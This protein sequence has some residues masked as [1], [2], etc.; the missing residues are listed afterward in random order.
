MM[1]EFSYLIC[2]DNFVL[3]VRVADSS[4]VRLLFEHFNNKI[5]S[6]EP[7]ARSL[8]ETEIPSNPKQL[9]KNKVA[10]IFFS[11]MKKFDGYSVIIDSFPAGIDELGKSLL[12]RIPKLSSADKGNTVE[13]FYFA[14]KKGGAKGHVDH[15]REMG[16][17]QLY[18]FPLLPAVVEI[19]G[20]GFIQRESGSARSTDSGDGGVAAFRFHLINIPMTSAGFSFL[21][22]CL[23]SRALFKLFLFCLS[24]VLFPTPNDE[25]TRETE[26]VHDEEEGPMEKG[27]KEKAVEEQQECRADGRP[28]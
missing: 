10:D 26:L 2:P 5:P 1:V 7:R 28:G 14:E 22:V 24:L 27:V 13:D 19:G 3:K 12:T 4:A 8:G 11:Y 16:K 17:G 6:L 23:P 9:S 20:F 21:L 25:E 15:M 18:N